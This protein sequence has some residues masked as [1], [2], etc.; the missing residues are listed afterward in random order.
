VDT[1]FDEGGV[2]FIMPKDNTA[3]GIGGLFQK[4]YH[5]WLYRQDE[6]FS[7]WATSSASTRFAT[8]AA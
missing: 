3:S 5:Y 8:G 7:P 2:P 1:V 4:M 6:F